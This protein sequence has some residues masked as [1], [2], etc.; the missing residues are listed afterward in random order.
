MEETRP[1]W[2]LTNRPWILTTLPLAYLVAVA[3]LSSAAFVH[4]SCSGT[5]G[6]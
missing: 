3:A 2:V 1:T 6:A 5:F 4:N